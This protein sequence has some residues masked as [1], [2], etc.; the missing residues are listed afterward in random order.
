MEYVMTASAT[1]ITF[2][3]VRLVMF[4][5]ARLLLIVQ[6]MD[7]VARELVIAQLDGKVRIVVH[8]LV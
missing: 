2:G 3:V 5:C 4:L 6:V 1:A 8:V 7:C